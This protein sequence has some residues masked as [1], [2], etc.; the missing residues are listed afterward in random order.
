MWV[1]IYCLMEFGFS[2]PGWPWKW[3]LSWGEVWHWGEARYFHCCCYQYQDTT[4]HDDDQGTGDQLS[5]IMMTNYT[6]CQVAESNGDRD[7]TGA[8][9]TV[10]VRSQWAFDEE[11]NMWTVLFLFAQ[12]VKVRICKLSNWFPNTQIFIILQN[13]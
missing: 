2:Y 8:E 9:P 10:R 6:R 3:Q 12:T 1:K 5:D 11:T 7:I 13:K 4:W